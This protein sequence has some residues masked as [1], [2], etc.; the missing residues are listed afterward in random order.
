M[1]LSILI[2][3]R[4]EEWLKN[5]VEDILKNIEDETEVLVGLD[6][7]WADPALIQNDRVTVLYVPESIG[8]RA[9]TNRLAKLSKAKY[10]M[11]VDAHCSF[12]KGF[13]RKLIED[14]KDNWT[15][16]PAMKNLHVFDWRCS[17][18]F[19][20]YQGPTIPCPECGKEMFREV[21]WFAKP[22]PYSTSYRV[23]DQLEFKY[24]G[25]YKKKQVGNIVDTM[26]L[27]GS[28]F[29]LTREKY[30]ELDI[31][32]ESWGSWG[33]QGAEMALKTWLSGGEV[34][35]N[36][37]TWYA[38]LFRT[39]GGDFGF[40]YA[41]PGSEQKNAKNQLRK[42]FLYDKW[43]KAKRKLSWLLDKF[44][45]VPGWEHD[46]DIIFYTDN[47]LNL[48]IAHM[49]QKQ[50]KS[51]GLKIISSSL[52]P[53][54]F[55]INEVTKEKRGNLAYF[56]QIVNAL[57]RSKADIVYFCEHDVLYHPSHF[58]FKPKEERNSI[59]IQT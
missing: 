43:P 3:A 46:R 24:F 44:G 27:Q 5:T 14:M 13:D 38:H 35:V 57:E 39:Q 17:C 50:L 51:I 2:P 56:K 26:S 22:S 33:G 12:D 34:K 37:N 47:K 45:P 1:K 4:N 28:C 6:G 18:G 8:Q 55:G 40:P 36:K 21:K 25:E 23:N 41:N 10:V 15:V 11:K 30:W 16:A 48:K 52:K 32:D 49:V 9:M 54:T 19:T 31:C 29:M 59:L 53:M 7:K 58:D 42:I 20:K